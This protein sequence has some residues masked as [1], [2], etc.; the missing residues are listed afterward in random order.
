VPEVEAVVDAYAAR[1]ERLRAHIVD[2]SRLVEELA[3]SGK[4][5]IVEG[6]F[7]TMVDVDHGYYPFVV[8]ASTVAGGAAV[9]V[10]IAPRRIDRVVGVAKAYTTRSGPG[11]LPSELSGELAARLTSA[12][13]E[14]SPTTAKPR[15][16]G[17]FD[18]PILRYAA[19]VNGFD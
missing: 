14:L 15:R 19:R 11:P 5:V 17:M 4:R 8:A 10:G 18:V 9:G 6:G 16:C 13:G 2:G 3:R 7:G 1:G 12:G